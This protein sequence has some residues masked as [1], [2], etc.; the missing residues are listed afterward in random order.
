MIVLLDLNAV[1][2]GNRFFLRKDGS[3][4]IALLLGIIPILMIARKVQIDLSLLQF[5]FLYTED[6]GIF[7]LKKIQKSLAHACAKT[8]DVP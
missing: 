5:G 4:G 3:S 7:R 6:V 2:D 1:R 8:V